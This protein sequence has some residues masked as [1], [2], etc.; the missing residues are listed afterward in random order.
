MQVVATFP[1]AASDFLTIYLNIFT[2][3]ATESVVWRHVVRK[4][5]PHFQHICALNSFGQACWSRDMTKSLQFM[6]SYSDSVTFKKINKECVALWH[7]NPLIQPPTSYN[8]SPYFEVALSG[9]TYVIWQPSE[10]IVFI[11]KIAC[12]LRFA[13]YIMSQRNWKLRYV[14]KLTYYDDH[15]IK[16]AY[17]WRKLYRLIK[18]VRRCHSGVFIT[19]IACCLRF[20]WYIMIPVLFAVG[21]AGWPLIERACVRVHLPPFRRQFCFPTLPGF[22]GRNSNRWNLLPCVYARK[23]TDPRR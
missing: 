15:L 17:R 1:Q 19:K 22:F 21:A 11:T 7:K 20:T 8:E 14:K 16:S 13:W 5:V 18:L 4:T 2:Y 3:P 23:V 9:K 6:S 10:W 12:W